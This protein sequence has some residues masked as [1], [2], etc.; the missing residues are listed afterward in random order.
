VVNDIGA[1][2][3]RFALINGTAPGADLSLSP[4]R[5]DG[6]RNFANKI[7]NA[8]RF[9][10]DKRP[11][12]VPADVPLSLPGKGELGPA[13]HW[14][15]G[16]AV[17]TL[18]QVDE[19]Y[20]AFQF[21]DAMRILQSAIWSEYCDW[22]LELAKVQ[23]ADA[24][25]GRRVAT[26][27]VLSWVLERYLRVLHPVMPHLTE[28]IWARMPHRPDD[29][30]LLIVARWPD[31]S[32]GAGLVDEEL[33]SGTAGLLEL[34]TAIRNARTDAGIDPTTRLAATIVLTSAAAARAYP[35][36]EAGLTRLAQVEP[37]IAA[38]RDLLDRIQGGLA[39]LTPAAEARLSSTGADRERE[40]TRIE[41]ERAEAERM[42]AAAKA[43][44]A[45]PVFVERAPSHI[46]D[47]ARERAD[48]LAT[49]IARLTEHLEGLA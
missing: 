24:A 39:V 41:R 13:E 5:L 20:A 9:V 7:W 30:D 2:A 8:A 25:S 33:A 43:R 37:T 6:A 11:P 46:V 49:R 4:S 40:R 34:I 17:E 45:D 42:L 35:A 48:E 32:E 1:D 26:W 19:A 47:G 16:R 36:L 27:R 31:A 22:Y 29:P 15:L 28:E 23:L 21:G 44:L 38:D 14:I 18:T 10:L 3:L 12:D